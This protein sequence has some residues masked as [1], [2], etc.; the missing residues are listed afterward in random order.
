VLAFFGWYSGLIDTIQAPE[1]L[2]SQDN[3]AGAVLSYTKD[4]AQRE[5]SRVVRPA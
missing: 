5:L 2:E 3:A 4:L 1:L